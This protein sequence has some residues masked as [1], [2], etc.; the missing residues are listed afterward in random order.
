MLK[1]LLPLLMLLSFS[2]IS[3][4]DHFTNATSLS[5]CLTNLPAT[6]HDWRL[7]GELEVGRA[8]LQK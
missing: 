4:K 7:A 8:C 6:Y 2:S 5:S 3:G 1:L